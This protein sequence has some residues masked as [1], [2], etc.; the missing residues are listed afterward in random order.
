MDL[1]LKKVKTKVTDKL[2]EQKKIYIF[3]IIVM[4]IGMLLGIIYAIILNKSDHALVTTSLDSFFTSIKNNDI[5]YKSALINSLIG[6]ISF[7]TFIFLLGISII[8]IPIIIFS[9]ATSSFIFGFS[10]SSIIYTYHLNGILKAITYLFPHQLITLLMS[11]FLGFYALYFGIKLF[12]Y[13]F[14][15]VDINLRSSMKRYIQVYVTVLLIFIGCS[16]I[17]VF[18]SPALIKLVV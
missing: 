1:K 2:R 6:N 14:R 10:L 5:D 17:E 9:L 3:L 4:I 8:G 11:L 15:G 16:F 12:K 7:V 13:L 18:I